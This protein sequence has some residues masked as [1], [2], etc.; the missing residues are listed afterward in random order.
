[1]HEIIKMHVFATE[2]EAETFAQ[3]LGHG[4][5]VLV[6]PTATRIAE[7]VPTEGNRRRDSGEPIWV[8]VVVAN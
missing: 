4:V 8:V 3:T 2:E 6:H 1:M 5:A 7:F